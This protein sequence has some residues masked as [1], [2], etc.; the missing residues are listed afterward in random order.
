MG[1]KEMNKSDFT[2]RYTPDLGFG[3]QAFWDWEKGDEG[4]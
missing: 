1:W 4:S 2:T 3:K